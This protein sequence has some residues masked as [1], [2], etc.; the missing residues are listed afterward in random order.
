MNPAIDDLQIVVRQVDLACPYPPM[1]VSEGGKL[2][3]LVYRF[4]RGTQQ[5]ENRGVEHVYHL[6]HKE[7]SRVGTRW[8]VGQNTARDT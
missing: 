1:K 3:T 4:A 8:A 5:Q 6:T 7:E 2:P